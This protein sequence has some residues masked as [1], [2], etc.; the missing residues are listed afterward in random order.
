VA[1]EAEDLSAR[2]KQLAS[3]NEITIELTEEQADAILRQWDDANPRR[4]ARLRFVV[5]SRDIAELAVAGY[6][7]R[8]D[9]CCV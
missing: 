2:V 5:E 7:Y 6:R 4:P 1:E 8:G 3:E 9:T